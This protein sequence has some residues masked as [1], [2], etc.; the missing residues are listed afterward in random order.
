MTDPL[1]DLYEAVLDGEDDLSADLTR[2]GLD[3]GL[4]P[5]VLIDDAMIPAMA[6]AGQ[7]FEDEEYFV[8]E[9]LLAGRAITAGLEVL[10]PLLAA[11]ELSRAGTVVIG[12]V[13]GDLHDIGKNLVAVMLEGAGFQVIDLGA[14]VA[15]ATVVAAI[16]EH[17]PD[18]LGLSALLTTTML[19]MPAT[20]EAIAAAGLRDQVK[21]L[22]GGAPLSEKWAKEF[23]ADAYADN[24]NAAVRAATALVEGHE[25]IGTSR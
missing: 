11:T 22:V 23:G 19:S 10:R 6:E 17:Q 8:P 2:V 25:S 7:L 18:M 1:R 24:A 15:P 9:L 14:D 5:Q 12:T 21:V 20:I 13:E 4:A 16:E 3:A